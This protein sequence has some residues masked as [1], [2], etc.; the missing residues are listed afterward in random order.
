MA[1]GTPVVAYARGSVPE[2]VKDGETGFLVN[3]SEAD[4]R[5]DWVI[6]KT[7]I[8]GLCEAIEKIYSMS[9][10]EYQKMRLN[11]RSLVEKSFSASRMAEKYLKIYR[12]RY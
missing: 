2:I 9:E 3:P 1:C 8:D 6:K 10:K 4:I 7:G 5:G 11:C 12:L